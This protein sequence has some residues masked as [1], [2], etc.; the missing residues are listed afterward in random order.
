MVIDKIKHAAKRVLKKAKANIGTKHVS[1]EVAELFF[2]H[3][4]KTDFQRYDMIVR[5]LAVENYYGKNDIG[6]D[7][8]YRMQEA[9]MGKQ[10]ADKA[11]GI[12]EN[13][14]KSYQENGYDEKSEIELDSNLHL[15]DGSHR[16][17]MAMYH[18]VPK[19]SAKVRPYVIN[20]FYGIE[21]FK[22]NGFSD[23]ECTMLTKKYRELKK[24]YSTP[25]VC[26]LW[27][28]VHDY[29][30]EITE[31]LR[32][33]GEVTEIRDFDL[34]DFDYVFYTRGIYHVDDIEKWKIEKKIEYMRK[35]SPNCRKIRMVTL[36]LEE[37]KFRL[38]ANT[39]TT[40]SQQ[41]E[42]IKR[43]IRDAYKA[44]VNHYF[45]DI[46]MHIGDNF[47]QN[48]HIYRL[49]TMPSIDVTNILDHIKDRKYVLTKIESPYMSSEF[50]M[51]YPLGKDLDI[52]CADMDEYKI[53]LESILYDIK[54]YEKSYSIRLVKK[55]DEKGREYRTLV[56]LEQEDQFLV[57]QFDVASRH[58]TGSAAPDIIDEMIA[59]RQKKGIYYIPS[60]EC[61]IVIRLQELHQY[62][63]KIH[64][65]DY[66]MRYKDEINENL[67]DKYLN[68]DWR[69]ILK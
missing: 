13:L 55:I 2:Q 49:L 59:S 7:L 54:Q 62:P 24:L 65:R 26:S 34:S 18:Q 61:E 46:V 36:L 43:L 16:M 64:H 33:F 15:I 52:I 41:C 9:R 25:F 66:V 57:F 58:R 31:K 40:L 69:K 37:P 14:I 48:R 45:H 20:I 3:N 47:Y 30:D 44:K 23:E 19:I 6:F 4:G 51:H 21:W 8:Y 32:M 27:A 35:S 10:W 1:L 60:I 11:V 50:P 63:K 53:V 67:C 39:N 22:V 38:K 28:P 29:F 42:L 5:L 17:A 12:F 56:R 68:M